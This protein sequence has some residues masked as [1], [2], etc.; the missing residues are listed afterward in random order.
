MHLLSEAIETYIESHSSTHDEVLAQLTRETHLKVQMP[1]M[2]SGNI[3]GKF[4][5]MISRMCAPKRILEI[6]T[7]TGYSAICLARGL[8]NDGQLI[9]IDINEELKSM[10][11][12]Y[13]ELAG[14]LSKIKSLYGDAQ[15]IVP[16]LKEEFDI[17]FIDADKHNY[18]TYYDLVFDKVKQGGY[19]IADNV[20]WSGKVVKDDKDKDTL[21]MHQYNEKVKNDSR[22]YNYI[23]PLRD[24]LNIA[25]KL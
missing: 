23:L 6:G 9:T 25:R 18:S 10:C 20:L 3:Q 15:S 17:V 1:Q 19:I 2:L 12:K 16:S 24:G 13:F 11:E 14:V 22:V 5:E 21:A 7:F 8:S 4:L